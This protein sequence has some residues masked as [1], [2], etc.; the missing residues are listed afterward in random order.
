MKIRPVRAGLFQADGRTDR[1][2]DMT[3]VLVAFRIL[4]TRPKWA[5]LHLYSYIYYEGHRLHVT[6][7]FCIL[8]WAKWKLYVGTFIWSCRKIKCK[9]ALIHG[10]CG[11]GNGN[12]ARI[13]GKLLKYLVL[14]VC[15]IL[16]WATSCLSR[17]G[18][19]GIAG[20]SA[21]MDRRF[22]FKL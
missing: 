1:H 11:D 22:R 15:V 2:T 13:R 3:K 18:V 14:S 17:T 20:S 6:R 5:D 10:N 7:T 8:S 21:D 16:L 9:M 4:R 19:T 12:Q